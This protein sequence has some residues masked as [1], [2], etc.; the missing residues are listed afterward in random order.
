MVNVLWQPEY[1][2][3]SGKT[4]LK[5]PYNLNLSYDY[6]KLTLYIVGRLKDHN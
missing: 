3:E 5:M 4:K 2:P 1:T 6:H